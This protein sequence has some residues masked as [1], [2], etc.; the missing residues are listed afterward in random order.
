[1]AEWFIQMYINTHIKIQIIAE[2]HRS[3]YLAQNL[4]HSDF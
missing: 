4:E 2:G 3:K 1:M